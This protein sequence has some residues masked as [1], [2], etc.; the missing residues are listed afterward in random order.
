[1]LITV[2]LATLKTTKHILNLVG[3]FTLQYICIAQVVSQPIH[4]TLTNWKTVSLRL[5]AK[6]FTTQSSVSVIN[7]W[8]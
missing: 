1:M 3:Y 6:I 8:W 5:Y 7:N 2:K 4:E